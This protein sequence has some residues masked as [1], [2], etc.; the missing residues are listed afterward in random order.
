[1]P[2]PPAT[3][4]NMSVSATQLASVFNVTSAHVRALTKEGTLRCRKVNGTRYRY[5]L[6]E[7]VRAFAKHREQAAKRSTTSDDRAYGS[8]RARRMNAMADMAELELKAKQGEY[9]YKP[10]VEFHLSMLLRNC[11]DRLLAIPSRTMF[12]LVGR[13]DAKDCN[14]IV[15]TEVDLALNEIADQRCFD[16]ARMRKDEIAYLQSEGYTEEQAI[17]TVDE[18]ERRRKARET[19]RNGETPDSL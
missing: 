17:E 7:S 2:T 11:R 12:Q 1:M 5:K 18:S 3:I 14:K 13:T 16:W 9:L 10:A 4:A 8:G 15:G 6:G 19:E